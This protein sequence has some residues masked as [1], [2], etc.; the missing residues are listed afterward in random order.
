MELTPLRY[1][2]AVA[3]L[4]HVTQASEK[5]NVAQPAITRSIRRLEE[6]LGVPLVK[7]KGRNIVLTQYGRLL[8]EEIRKPLAQLDRIPYKLQQIRCQN[9]QTIHINVTAASR[10]ITSYIIQ[11]KKEHPHLNFS[12]VQHELSAF[13]DICI[14]NYQDQDELS[15]VRRKLY[16]ERIL[17]AVPQNSALAKKSSLSLAELKE[18]EFICMAGNFK[19]RLVC[20]AICRKYGFTP[21][22]V[23]ESDNPDAVRNLIEAGSG[24]GFWPEHSWGNIGEGIKLLKLDEEIGQRKIVVGLCENPEKKAALEFYE[25][26]IE[27]MDQLLS[28]E[29]ALS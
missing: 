14:A 4:Q 26:L 13:S 5:M 3:E 11:Y 23:F 29:H 12:I 19:F 27:Q 18:E 28:S 25:A 8:Y 21:H 24:I 9:E 7:A 2:A 22:I 1:F 15:F 17:L 16:S 10:L 6:E 20:D